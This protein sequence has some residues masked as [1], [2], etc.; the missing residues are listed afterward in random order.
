M[1]ESD[2]I[3]AFA[4]MISPGESFPSDHFRLSESGIDPRYRLAKALGLLEDSFSE[5]NLYQFWTGHIVEKALLREIGRDVLL[6][7]QAKVKTPWGDV[8]HID[9]RI[10]GTKEILEIKTTSPAQWDNLPHN[11][12]IYQVQAYLYYGKFEKAHLIYI[13]R[14]GRNGIKVFPVLPNPTLQEEIDKTLSMLHVWKYG[15]VY[16]SPSEWQ[17]AEKQI[18]SFRHYYIPRSFIDW[19]SS[20]DNY[21]DLFSIEEQSAEFEAARSL[22]EEFAESKDNGDTATEKYCTEKLEEYFEKGYTEIPILGDDGI[23]T[24]KACRVESESLNLKKARK[25]GVPIPEEL[26]KFINNKVYWR[27]YITKNNN[28]E[29]VE[30]EEN[31]N[32]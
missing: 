24:L 32:N 16:P 18:G 1:K 13:D 21:S 31:G 7:R 4:G 26:S 10:R 2:I 17:E 20:Q 14:S 12:N 22:A 9:A 29:A 6:T 30:E 3:K 15:G 27:K 25:C 19:C 23:R 8:G 11:Y 5:E 28:G